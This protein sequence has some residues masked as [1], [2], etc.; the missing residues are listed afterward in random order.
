MIDLLKL[1]YQNKIKTLT[2][3]L[4]YYFFILPKKGWDKIK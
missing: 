1:F 4:Q 3:F 2:V